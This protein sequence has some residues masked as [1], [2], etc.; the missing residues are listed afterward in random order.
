LETRPEFAHRPAIEGVP[1][2]VARPGVAK[3]PLAHQDFF[4]RPGITAHPGLGVRPS[5]VN[6][7]EY[8]G[9]PGTGN[10]PGVVSGGGNAGRDSLAGSWYH[11]DWHNWGSGRG[12]QWYGRPLWWQGSNWWGAGYLPGYAAWQ[13]PWSWGYWSYYNPYYTQPLTFGA[14]TVDYSQPIVVAAPPTA[15]PQR[16]GEELALQYFDSARDAFMNGEYQQALTQVDKAIALLPSD[17]VLHEFR[18]LTLFALGDYQQ[19]AASVYAALSVGPGWDWTTLS[20]L[21]P[22]TDVYTQQLRALE[23]Y[24]GQHPNQSDARFLLAYQ[25]LTCGYT[26]QAIGQLQEVVQLNP[27]DQLSAQLLASLTSPQQSAAPG[28]PPTIAGSTEVP[29][30][31]PAA[32]V[33]AAALAGRWTATRPDG[34]TIALNL[35]ND[36]KYD[37]NYTTNG[38][39]HNFAGTFSIA[40]N[41][42]VLKQGDTPAM[43]GQVSLVNNR[44][45][46][47]K[48]PGDNPNDPGLTFTRG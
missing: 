26:E 7:P 10:R 12:N 18:G 43:V 47:F 38:Q 23:Q 28:A 5:L 42:L 9:R 1:D 17:A 4:G 35:G 20:A 46:N 33:S 25:Y 6:H 44:Q 21:Y 31:V 45:F 14:T 19:A 29:P 30:A 2:V 13:I 15:V 34:S 24:A 11:G 37:W 3:S 40:D 16:S 32:P 41:L 36:T 27:K 8:L 22:D 39:S 48:M